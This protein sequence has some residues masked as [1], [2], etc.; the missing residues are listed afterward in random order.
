MA[1]MSTKRAIPRVRREGGSIKVMHMAARTFTLAERL[2]MET[3][4]S[5]ISAMTAHIKP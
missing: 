2:R 1:M 4:R 3:V 5:P